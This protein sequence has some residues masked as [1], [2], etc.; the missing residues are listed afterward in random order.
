MPSLLQSL[1]PVIRRV[2]VATWGA[3]FIVVIFGLLPGWAAGLN[4][5]LGWPRWQTA[6]G[7]VIGAM[8]FL[9]SLGLAVYCSRLFL[10]IG[11][12]TP[13]PIDPPR[14]L[15]VSGLYRF[16]RNPIYVGQVGILLSYFL[17]SGA[18]TLLL[19]AGVWLLLVQGF[20]V[21]V[22]EPGLERRFGAA[23]LEYTR[24]VPRWVGIRARRQR[25]V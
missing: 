22:E 21:W 25:A 16:T 6:A 23:Y 17:Y 5:E 7:Q 14:E 12:G 11:K 2:I 4:R 8:F 20:V 19:Y 3:T 24:E 18:L 1:S 13:V 15:V 10:R 9:A